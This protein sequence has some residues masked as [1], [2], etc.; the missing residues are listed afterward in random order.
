M[1]HVSGPKQEKNE[2]WYDAEFFYF[3]ISQARDTGSIEMGNPSG[4]ITTPSCGKMDWCSPGDKHDAII[5]AGEGAFQ[6]V[7]LANNTPPG[8]EA[9]KLV[10]Q[11]SCD[12]STKWLA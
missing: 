2:A 10:L 12:T 6:F 9:Q 7:L 4:D 8:I 3:E 11:V 5:N 1:F